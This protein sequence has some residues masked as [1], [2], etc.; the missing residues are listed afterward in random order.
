[1]RRIGLTALTAIVVA[2]GFISTTRAQGWSADISAGRTVYDPVS[3]TVGT[4]NVIG[5]LRYDTRRGNWVYG[6]GALPPRDGG[7]FW[8]AGGTGGRVMVAS[9]AAGLVRIG[10]DLDAHGFWFRDRVVDLSGTGGT[11][12]AM[13]FVRATVGTGFVEGG[14]GWRGHTL[15]FAGVRENRGVFETGARAGRG[16]GCSSLHVEGS[17]RWVHASEATYPFVGATLAHQAARV[18][19]WVYTGRWLGT[20]LE[21]STWGAGSGVRLGARAA[22]WGSVRQ[23]ATDPLYWNPPRRTWSIGLTQRLGRIAAPLVPVSPTPAGVV[24]VRL[25]AADAPAGEVSIAGDFNNWQPAPMLR[26]GADWVVRLP[27]APGVYHYSFRS[28]AGQWF[29][30]ASVPG[31]RDDGMGGHHAVLVVS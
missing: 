16:Y 7:T 31:R 5:S 19:V 21:Q 2:F 11:V 6:A 28:S 15:S 22:I 17:V 20:A 13:P 1:V 27:L 26:E 29:V 23:E 3:A 24:V 12:E 10:A 8:G 14:A 4:S 25:P 9:P 30:P 18:D